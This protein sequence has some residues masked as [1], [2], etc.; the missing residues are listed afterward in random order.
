MRRGPGNLERARNALVGWIERRLPEGDSATVV[1]DAS[2]AARGTKDASSAGRIRVVFATGYDSADEWIID[3][4]SQSPDGAVVSN[5]G[6]I[7]AAARRS[8]VEVVSSDEFVARLSQEVSA[9]PSSIKP[10]EEGATQ[11]CDLEKP[12]VAL[13]PDEIEELRAFTAA[14]DEPEAAP[15]RPSRIGPARSRPKPDADL[16]DFY[17]TMRESKG[18]EE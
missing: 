15:I 9:Q 6:Q 8:R 4:C 16:E 14:S 13:T 5:D 3:E 10:R 17:R 11:G 7:Q 2:K 1:F 12:A 18:D